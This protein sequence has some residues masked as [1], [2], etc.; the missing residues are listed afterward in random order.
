MKSIKK[1][2]RLWLLSGFGWLALHRFYLG[3]KKTGILWVATLGFFG[4]GAIA[5]L[6]F[7][8]WLVKRQNAI[9]QIKQYKNELQQTVALKEQLVKEQRYDEATLKRNRERLL[10]TK[11][12]ELNAVLQR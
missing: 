6:F 9:Y 4:I 10:I 5:D 8:K 3:K 11:L 7:L 12:H 1:A 2:Y